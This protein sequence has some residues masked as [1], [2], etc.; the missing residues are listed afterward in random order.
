MRRSRLYQA[1]SL[2][3]GLAVITYLLISLYLPSPRWLIF[4][5]D[6]KTGRVRMV[7]QGVTFLPPYEYY[8][9]K[10]EK[11]EGS[12]QR[13]DFVQINSKEGVPVKLY[14]RLRFGVSGEQVR[15]AS[16]IVQQGWNSWTRAR[17]AEAVTAVASQIPIEDLLSP[18]SSFNVR[19]DPLRQAVSRHLAAS[20]LK[21]TGFEIARL[22]VDRPALL[23][24][25][26][27]ELR[28]DARS[29]P[30]RT[31]VFA[32]DGADWEL[33]SELSSDGRI[34]N[35]KALAQGGTT[36]SLQTIQP[37]ISPMVWTTVATGVSPDR[38]GVLDF[39]DWAQHAPVNAYTR[40]AAAVWDIADAFGR[41]A[42]VTDW[43]TA[44]PP[45]ARGSVFFDTP[46][47]MTPG[48]TYP[49]ELAPR[50]QALTVPVDTIGY[51]QVRRF[52]NIS[53]EE[54]DTAV[55][56]GNANDPVKIF[57]S[58]L[59]KT[60]TDHRVAI[61]LYNDAKQ[62]G[63]E[64]ILTMVA[65][66]GT[67]AVNHLFA[68]FHPPYRE[69]IGETSYRKYWPAV[70]N[71][72][73]EI[74]RL[75]GEWMTI[76]PRET[77]V[78]IVSAHGFNWGRNRPRELPAGGSALSDHRSA[79]VFIAYGPLVAPSRAGHAISVYDVAPTILT[80]LGL[81]QS[82][83]M[84]GKVATWVF[85]SLQPITSVRVV[86]YGEFVGERPISTSSHLDPKA[87]Q[88][89]LQSVGHLND[90][91][92]NLSPVLENGEEPA[93]AAAPLPPEKWAQYAYQNNL[94]VDLR[95]KGKYRESIEAF[96]QAIALNPTRPAVYLNLAMAL[97]DRQQYTDADD[98]FFTAI[99]KGLPNAE[100][101][102]IDFAALY[103]ERQMIS[104][105][106]GI[107]AKG[108]E[109][110][111][112][113]YLIAANLGSALVQVSRYTEGVP[114]LERA[115]GLQPSSTLVLNNLGI[116]YAKK[117]DYGRALDFWN[118]SLA[119]NPRQ[120]TIRQ[121]VEAARSRL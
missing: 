1:V 118:R 14:Y 114:E 102:I 80:L 47:T 89:E 54:F 92:R 3:A 84:P 115:L 70:A 38:H 26:R 12:A 16:T 5:I 61:N 19:R 43:W 15:A 90:P 55:R 11:R 82:M 101:Y 69:G 119:I 44:W 56:G 22:E 67:D 66:E 117:N 73:S 39:N 103:R 97:F 75:I 94:G 116:F 112:Q 96:Q 78:I 60:W 30:T 20:G 65:Y 113:S 17:V 51:D 42:Q 41:P 31:V 18:T 37:T 99:A 23:N 49:P 98:V 86:S 40:R 52:L 58:L 27:A 50:A 8:R 25:K 63:R 53:G 33:L 121:A 83:E 100:S 4:G 21:V 13:D 111:P 46:V 68:P 7:E 87:Y 64:P 72:Y 76:L 93:Q 77:T 81:P 24:A 71:Y 85:Q 2:I 34:P 29:A 59:A 57:R 35:I 120:A 62:R 28:R 108:K 88:A 45:S 110:F 95:S 106:I 10:F 79:G 104:R 36:A 91:S 109:L 74:D 32:L 105:A 107:L 9:L 48:A 6:K